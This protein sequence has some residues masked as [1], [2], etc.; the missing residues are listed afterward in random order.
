MPFV[1]LPH[2][3]IVDDAQH[4]N[5][6]MMFIVNRADDAGKPALLSSFGPSQNDVSFERLKRL[7]AGSHLC[8]V[9]AKH[10]PKLR[11]RLLGWLPQSRR[12]LTKHAA[13]ALVVQHH[14]LRAPEHTHWLLSVE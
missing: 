1:G 6:A 7:A 9:R 2:G 5:H 12:C 4:S 3:G 10:P 8:D 14:I 11:A 13:E